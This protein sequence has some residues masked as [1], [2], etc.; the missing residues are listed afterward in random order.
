MPERA[1]TAALGYPVG[2]RP[3]GSTLSVVATDAKQPPALFDRAAFERFRFVS[4]ELDVRGG[5]TLRYAL[6]DEIFFVERLRPAHPGGPAGRGRARARGGAAVAAAL[7]CRRQL[8]QDRAAAGGRLRGSSAIAGDRGAAGS[9]VLGGPRRARVHQRPARA[10]PPEVHAVS[11]AGGADR[12]QPPPEHVRRA[13]P[14]GSGPTALLRRV[15]VPVGGGKDSAVALEIVRRSGCELSLFSVGDAPPIAR[16][17]AVGGPPAFDR[18]AHTRP[19]TA[20]A[21]R[22]RAH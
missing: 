15:L 5:V 12:R 18:Q 8:L 14:P 22:A 19:G 2:S 16:T 1:R 10:T 20:R 13:W 21:E 9:L 6:D 7:G 11:A 3:R 17:V 4:R